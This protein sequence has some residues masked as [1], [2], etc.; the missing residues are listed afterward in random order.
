MCLM[1]CQVGSLQ[2]LNCLPKVHLPFSLIV[3]DVQTIADLLIVKTDIL[4]NRKQCVV[5][6]DPIS[7]WIIVTAGVHQGYILAPLFF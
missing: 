6:N 3:H 1:I 2:I 5:L 7:S 4:N